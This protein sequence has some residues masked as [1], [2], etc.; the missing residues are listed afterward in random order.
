MDLLVLGFP[1][2]GTSLVAQILSNMGFNFGSSIDHLYPK[3]LNPAGFYQRLDLH[4]FT[5]TAGC[6]NLNPTLK[7]PPEEINTTLSI[8]NNNIAKED[9]IGAVKDP[10]LLY[11]L[12]YLLK[13][14]P[15]V[16]IIIIIRNFDDV[17][18]SGIKFQEATGMTPCICREMCES[19][20]MYFLS[21]NVPFIPIIYED[22]V[23]NYVDW[24]SKFSIMIQTKFKTVSNGRVENI[25]KCEI[26]PYGLREI[27]IRSA[28][29]NSKLCFD[30]EIKK[31]KSNQKCLCGS[32]KKFKKCCRSRV[33]VSDW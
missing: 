14:N 20:Y 25:R 1:R 3:Y 18:Q 13:I 21:L 12:P 9:G 6:G 24:Y 4:E 22:M 7:L 5:M 11:I 29:Q 2:S 33:V 32:G 10:Y 27:Y 31:F 8:I 16:T 28:L 15:L 26:K 17:A 30:P 19:Y 23:N